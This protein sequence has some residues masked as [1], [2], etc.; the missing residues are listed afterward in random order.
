VKS[1]LSNTSWLL[2]ERIV[3]ILFS[4]VVGAWVA[5]YLGVAQFGLLALAQAVVA[6]LTPFATVGLE[7]VVIRDLR[8]NGADSERVLGSAFGARVCG[9]LVLFLLAV[10]AATLLKPHNSHFL[11]LVLLFALS[12]LM[13]APDVIDAWFQARENM[14]PTATARGGAFLLATALRGGAIM[15]TLPTAAFAAIAIAESSL[16]S[17]L[18]VAF[19]RRTGRRLRKWRTSTAEIGHLI[20]RSSPLLVSSIFY[21]ITME[22]DKIIVARMLGDQAAGIYAAAVRLS[23]LWYFIPLAFIASIY[24]RLVASHASG[25]SGYRKEL[26]LLYGVTALMG[27]GA[28]LLL[29]VAAP[30]IVPL[31]YGSAYQA[32]AAVLMAHAPSGFFIALSFANGRHLIAENM[33]RYLTFRS[34]IAGALNI[35]LTCFLAGKYGTVGAALAT[36]ISYAGLVLSLLMFRQTRSHVALCFTSPFKIIKT[37]YAGTARTER[38]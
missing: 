24:P 27:A 9:C 11:T 17:L 10:A 12:S 20:R 21:L 26:T 4:L 36:T 3:R 15:M 29:V 28:S 38:T 19:Y 6:L 14:K 13:L 31:M 32:S 22:A 37:L 33:A 16:F 7:S 25:G 18:L 35:I 8:R 34:C 5:R 30:V 2:F 1:L 23:E